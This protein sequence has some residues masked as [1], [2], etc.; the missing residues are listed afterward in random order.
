MNN[1]QFNRQISPKRDTQVDSEPQAVLLMIADISGYTQ[2]MLANQ[3]DLAHSQVV[4]TELAATL[5]RAVEIPLEISKLEGDAIF[6]YVVKRNDEEWDR[7]K[8]NISDKLIEFGLIF[9]EKLRELNHSNLCDCGACQHLDRL[10]LKIVVHSGKAVFYEIRGAK[11]VAGVDVI[12]VHR[13]L[14]NSLPHDEYIMM[15]ETAYQDLEFPPELAI[16]RHQESF[17]ELG[18]VNSHVIVPRQMLE[19]TQRHIPFTNYRTLPFQAKNHLAKMFYPILHQLKLK[20]LLDVPQNVPRQASE[21][22]LSTQDLFTLFRLILSIVLIIDGLQLLLADR[23]ALVDEYLSPDGYISPIF[24]DKIVN[25][26]GISI[27]TFLVLVGILQIATGTMTLVQGDH[28]RIAGIMVAVMYWMFAI[29]S[30]MA[31]EIRLGR[32][33]A[34]IGLS[35]AIALTDPPSWSLKGELRR[36]NAIL[37]LVRLSLAYPLLTSSLFTEGAFGN[38]FNTT[39]SPIVAGILGFSLLIGIFP[40]MGVAW[41]GIW[42]LYIIG[43]KLVEMGLISGVENIRLE[44]GLLGGASLYLMVGPD[45]YA[46]FKFGHPT[47]RKDS[48]VTSNTS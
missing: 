10:R 3:R 6:M 17:I 25:G 44:L 46:W 14:K 7:I 38:H 32:H 20:S 31:G 15:T 33:M 19:E 37:L 18:L 11:E 24:E 16:V 26:L 29:I 12:L 40:R 39:L 5:I 13:L 27:V 42:L 4:L 30:P 47:S 8:G 22:L 48:K 9:R 35:I 23:T 1:F 45:D 41:L 34:L 21:E 43:A 2:F 36:K 28:I